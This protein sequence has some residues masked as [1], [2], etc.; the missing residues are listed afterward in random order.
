V[1][2][3][4]AYTVGDAAGNFIVDFAV[5]PK[6]IPD[7]KYVGMSYANSHAAN[8]MCCEIIESVAYKPTAT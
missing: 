8:L 4:K 6:L 1:Q 3:A 5:D 2:V 7:G